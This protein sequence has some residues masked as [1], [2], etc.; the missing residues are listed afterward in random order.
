MADEKNDDVEKPPAVFVQ[1]GIA[2]AKGTSR[3]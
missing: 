3:E 2:E 1:A